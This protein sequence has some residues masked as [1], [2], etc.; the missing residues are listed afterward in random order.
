MNNSEKKSTILVV[1][2]EAVIG[3]EIQARLIKHGYDVPLV[4]DTGLKAISK[5]CEMQPDLILMDISLKGKMNGIEASESIRKQFSIPIVFLTANTDAT[6]FKQAKSSAPFGY[7]Q[8]PFQENALLTSIEIAL[9]KGRAEK[10]LYLYRNHLEDM[11]REKTNTLIHIN[12]ELVIAKEAAEEANNAKTEFLANMSHEIRTPMNIILGNIRLALE[13][14]LSRQQ[15]RFLES[16]YHSSDSLLHILNDILDIS[17]IEAG[18]L[19]IEIHSFDLLEVVD[20]IIQTFMEDAK[21][22]GLD[23]SYVISPGVPNRLLGDDYR[24]EQVLNNLLDNAIKFTD[25][26]RVTLDIKL[27]SHDEKGATL[28]FCVADTGKGIHEEFRRKIFNNFT[29]KDSSVTRKFGGLGI[30]LTIC[31]KLVNLLGGKIW[32][33]SEPGK[34]SKFYFTMYFKIERPCESEETAAQENQDSL[35]VNL[36]ILLVED[37]MFNRELIKQVLERKGYSVTTATDGLECLALLTE[38]DFSVVVMDIQMPEMDGIEATKHIR[39]CERGDSFT[40]HRHENLLNRLRERIQ[41]KYT[42]VVALTAHAMAGDRE[43]CLEAGM[44]DYLTKPFQPKSDF[45]IIG[46][47]A[48][49]KNRNNA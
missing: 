9:Y 40:G 48:Q 37:N 15:S 22:K 36:N 34:G 28:L 47:V 17:K 42:P 45:Q 16:A 32:L 21:D 49:V 25:S 35:E 7:I 27:N 14:K 38:N 6:T 24:I 3:M 33:E 2:D 39:E 8:K 12:Q 5:A 1:E 20:R 4:V 41:G 29:Q 43:Q 11:V 26:G 10:E 13:T 31:D 23:L 46:R 30:G 18:E 44:D 19:S